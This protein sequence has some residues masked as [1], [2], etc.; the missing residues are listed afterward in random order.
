VSSNTAP[1]P[2]SAKSS[3][4]DSV[5]RC[6][7]SVSFASRS[8]RSILRPSM[9]PAAL[10]QS[11]KT[12]E[13]SN[14]SWFRPGRP[15][16]P[17]SETVPTLIESALTPC[18]PVPLVVPDFAG[19][20]TSFRVPKSPGPT[21]PP[22][23]VSPGAVVVLLVPLCTSLSSREHALAKASDATRTIAAHRPR[24]WRAARASI[25]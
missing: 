1:P 3:A 12:L 13:A 6:L 11:T 20:Q 18:E 17:G 7:Y 8:V 10:H 23:P 14:S 2:T 16:K 19:P 24:P 22:L 5:M 21:P 15:T 4:H 25:R 9:P